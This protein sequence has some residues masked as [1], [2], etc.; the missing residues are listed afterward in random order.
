ME[1]KM[2]TFRN[3]SAAAVL[4]AGLVL[5]GCGAQRGQ[6]VMTYGKGDEPPPLMEADD[7]ATYALY[8]NTSANPVY[9]QRLDEGDEFGFVKKDDGTVVGMIDGKEV[10]LQS[11]VS[12]GYYWKKQQK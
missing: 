6:T 10:P 1:S 2:F 9:S 7:R 5:T 8:P 4:I 11:T 12:T 3:L